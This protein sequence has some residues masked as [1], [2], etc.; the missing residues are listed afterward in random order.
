MNLFSTKGGVDLVKSALL[1]DPPN[2]PTQQPNDLPWCLCG[3]CRPMPTEVEKKCCRL[4]TCV[5]RTD[6]FEST[7]LDLNVLSI[8]ILNRSEMF[9]S[10][11]DDSP[12]SY[13][14]AAYRQYILWKEGRLGRGNR[15]VVPSCVVWSVRT[16]Y[17]APDG[18]YLGFKEYDE[19]I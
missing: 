13:R 17:P 3:Y 16:R 19:T 15:V 2:Q 7:V 18:Q 8:A 10:S 5:T 9:V 12:A 11:F 6:L 14:K 4:R 1:S